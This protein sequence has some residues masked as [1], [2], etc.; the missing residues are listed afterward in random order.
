ML[1]VCIHGLL[2]PSTIL[3]HFRRRSAAAAARRSR[4][5]NTEYA[6]AIQSLFLRGEER[7]NNARCSALLK[8]NPQHRLF[9]IVLCAV[10]RYQTQSGWRYFGVACTV[11]D[12]HA[13]VLDYFIWSRGR[14][15]EGTRRAKGELPLPCSCSWGKWLGMAWHGMKGWDE[16]GT[17][18]RSAA[19]VKSFGDSYVLPH[20]WDGASYVRSQPVCSR[21]SGRRSKS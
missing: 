7:G 11:N 17:A 3:T 2:P 19:C 9:F 5:D 12:G 10:N 8:L 18:Q 13:I 15:K 6:Y 16:R 20:A 4:K 21:D 1:K 14:Q